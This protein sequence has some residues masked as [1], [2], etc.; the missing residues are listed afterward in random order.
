MDC[1][2]LRQKKRFNKSNFTKVVDCTISDIEVL[3]DDTGAP[4]C[5][6]F[7]YDVMIS[8]AHE[9]EYAIAYAMVLIKGVLNYVLCILSA[10]AVADSD[11]MELDAFMVRKKSFEERFL[12]IAKWL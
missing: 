1:R 2:T 9:K 6:C 11:I 12:H 10:L 4:V 8:I 5:T 7:D 3:Q